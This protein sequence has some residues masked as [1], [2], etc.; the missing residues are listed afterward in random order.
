MEFLS[1]PKLLA[2]AAHRAASRPEFLASVFAEFAQAE[3]KTES[4]MMR[5]LGAT[6]ETF[7]AAGLSLRPR[8]ASYAEDLARV[9][10]QWKLDLGQLS[11]VVRHVEVLAGM[12]PGTAP[13]FADDQGLLMA[14][15][16]RTNRKNSPAGESR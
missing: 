5:L 10:T 7:A 11:H 9:A 3:H 2:A 15:R 13:A 8:A 14:A 1:D 4:E 16:A 12:K 6:E